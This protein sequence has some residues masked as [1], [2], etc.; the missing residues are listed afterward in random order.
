MSRR[1]YPT[2]A[3]GA[4]G[5]SDWLHPLPGYRM[6]CCDCGLAHD[7]QFRV[8]DLGQVNFRARRNQRSTGQLRRQMVARGELRKEENGKWAR[9]AS[10][11]DDA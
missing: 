1:A 8:D 6:A 5:W 3:G 9:L 7:M 11:G 4:D 10:M 2:E